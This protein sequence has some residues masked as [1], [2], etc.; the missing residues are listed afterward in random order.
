VDPLGKL[1]EGDYGT[2]V[3]GTVAEGGSPLGPVH[4][5]VVIHSTNALTRAFDSNFEPLFGTSN[6]E[7]P[8]LGDMEVRLRFENPARGDPL[9]DLAQLDSCPVPGQVYEKLSITARARGPLREAFG[10]PEGTPGRLQM[11]GTVDRDGA[12]AQITIQPTGQ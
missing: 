12:R 11:M 4:V 9:P 8:T 6:P 1:D 7:G 3:S 10:L 5:N 2:S